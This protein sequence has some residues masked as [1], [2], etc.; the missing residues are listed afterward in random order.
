M[1]KTNLNYN[2]IIIGGVALVGLYLLNKTFKS[3][4]AQNYTSALS[5]ETITT[6]TQP[7]I[8]TDLRQAGATTRATGRQTTRIITAQNRQDTRLTRTQIRQD[9]RTERARN[10]QITRAK[11]WDMVF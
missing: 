4:T 9:A 11:I 2:V 3:P 10:R 5:G 1:A 8:R 6:A 7:T